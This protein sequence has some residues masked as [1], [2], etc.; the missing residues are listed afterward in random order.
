MD[1]NGNR[2]IAA[3]ELAICEDAGRHVKTTRHTA[4]ECPEEE[5]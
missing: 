3:H 1:E 2:E 4:T 5:L